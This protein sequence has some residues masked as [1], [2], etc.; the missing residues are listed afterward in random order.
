MF[1]ALILPVTL[2]HSHTLYYCKYDDGLMLCMSELRQGMEQNI[3]KIVFSRV[4]LFLFLMEQNYSQLCH[5]LTM[6]ITF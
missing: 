5:V 2:C 1:L 4:Y 3:V 6:P